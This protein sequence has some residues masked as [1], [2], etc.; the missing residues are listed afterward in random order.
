MLQ[1]PERALEERRFD[2]SEKLINARLAVTSMRAIYTA[3]ANYFRK[4]GSY[5]SQTGLDDERL[6]SESA[7]LPPGYCMDV[8]VGTL[9]GNVFKPGGKPFSYYEVIGSPVSI[10]T[11]G[12]SDGVKQPAGVT[13]GEEVVASSPDNDP[14]LGGFLRLYM[15]P[16]GIIRYTRLGES[17]SSIKDGAG[18]GDDFPLGLTP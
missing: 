6:V 18:V 5:A 11:R 4:H 13:S 9:E 3:E 10:F 12:F 14:H 17:V 16:D 8:F 1:M 2:T 15:A 7:F